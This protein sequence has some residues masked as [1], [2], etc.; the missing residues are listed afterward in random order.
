M[1]NFFCRGRVSLILA[2]T[3]A[4]LAYSQKKTLKIGDALPNSVW[5]APMEVVNHPQKTIK[6]SEDKDKLIL[7]DFWNTWCSACLTGFPKMEELQ[8]KFNG[9]IKILA[10]SNQNRATLEKFF[11][12]KNGQR[13]KEI[14]SVAGDKILH[15][16]FPH[17]GV[18]YIIWIKDGKLLNT[19]DGA[20][21]NENTI[22]EVLKGESSSLQT[23]VYMSR[24]RPLML[25]ESFDQE[26]G[27]SLTNYSLLS[28]GRIRSIGF[29]SGFHRKGNI[30]Y[31]RQFTNLSLLEIFTAITDEIF[32]Q[33]K[34]SF[35][36]KRIVIEAKNPTALDYIKNS[37][38]RVEDYNLYN[39][40]YI[41]PVSL[42]ESF[43]PMMLKNL[44]QFADYS[45]SIEKRKVKCL[46]LRR[47]SQ[48]DKIATKG[49]G[50]KY[51]FSTSE[52]D[53]QNISMYAFVNS[54]NG[55]PEIKL[56]IIDETGYT[57]NVDLKLLGISDSASLSKELS[58]YDLEI[59]EA[60]RDIN[61]LVI[62][63][64]S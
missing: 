20:Q 49:G 31:G 47:T 59:I 37:E 48:K 52:S 46:I 64:K 54:I 57:G 58:K 63:D 2:V 55:I 7:L 25:S 39:Y 19:T 13:Y 56:P 5:T 22:N 43:Y 34:E 6:L 45:A 41:V 29:G 18:P 28:K 23:V 24:E 33:R 35:S 61:V 42:S 26:K 3:V 62:K 32:Q 50:M 30:V 40:E 4:A 44:S 9:K 15:S 27:T 12:S 36:N 14:L 16:Q 8:K 38:G 60:D 53:L 1:K 11:A 17:K 21:V 51:R 10:V